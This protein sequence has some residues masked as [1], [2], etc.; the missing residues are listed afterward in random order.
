[1]NK[2]SHK[3]QT[4]LLQ[5]SLK[6]TASYTLLTDN[7]QSVNALS[8]KP[9][10]PTTA[11]GIRNMGNIIIGVPTTTEALLKIDIKWLTTEPNQ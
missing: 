9:L 7:K 2:V 11:D 3:I 4:S 5:P 10:T 8:S 6:Q 1:M